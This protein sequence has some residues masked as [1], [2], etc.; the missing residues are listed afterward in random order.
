VTKV[1]G[2]RT[3]G[4]TTRTHLLTEAPG[5]SV[6]IAANDSP[7]R[8]TSSDT[9]PAALVLRA[10][11][12]VLDTARHCK[13]SLHVGRSH[14]RY[15]STERRRLPL[16]TFGQ[17]QPRQHC[18]PSCKNSVSRK[19][20][21]SMNNLLTSRLTLDPAAHLRLEARRI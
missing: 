5:S 15:V 16:G 6:L 7:E 21:V 9:V 13:G 11:N 4:I 8:T 2:I 3:T 18:E 14:H 10:I 19:H 17:L 20:I 12:R 1:S